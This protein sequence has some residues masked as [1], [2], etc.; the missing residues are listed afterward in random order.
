[1]WWPCNV[2][3]NRT[4]QVKAADQVKVVAQAKVK[5]VAQIKAAAQV[6]PCQGQIITEEVSLQVTTSNVVASQCPPKPNNT[7]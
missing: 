3:R 7:S 2:L 4:A 5:T 1:M 6:S